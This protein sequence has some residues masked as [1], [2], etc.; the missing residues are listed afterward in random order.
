MR[1]EQP[2]AYHSENSQLSRFGNSAG[3]PHGKW[4]SEGPD[5]P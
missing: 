4:N 3:K 1:L 2:E 5:S